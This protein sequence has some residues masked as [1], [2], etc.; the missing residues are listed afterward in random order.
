[1]NL[2]EEP[3]ASILAGSTRQDRLLVS[4]WRIALSFAAVIATSAVPVSGQ[5][6]AKKVAPTFVVDMSTLSDKATSSIARAIG[7]LQEKNAA[8]AGRIKVKEGD[9]WFGLINRHYGYFDSEWPKTAQTMAEVIAETNGL[10]VNEPLRPNQVLTLP[11]LPTRPSGH[12]RSNIAQ[13]IKSREG[14]AKSAR[15]SSVPTILDSNE[16]LP[17]TI[18]T[19]PS[20][21][22]PKSSAGTTLVLQLSP[23]EG[24]QL[25]ETLQADGVA[26]EVLSASYLGPGTEKTSAQFPKLLDRPGTAPTTFDGALSTLNLRSDK[27]LFIVDFMD[28]TVTGGCSHGKKVS[29]VAKE[30]LSNAGAPELASNVEPIEVDFYRHK[31]Q[32]RD[33]LDR[34]IARNPKNVRP[35]LTSFETTILSENAEPNDPFRVPVLYLHAL[36][37]DLLAGGDAAAISSSFYVRF[38]GVKYLPLRYTP[39]SAVPLF[40]AVTDDDNFIEDQDS[41]SLVPL[42]EFFDIHSKYGVVLVG[43]VTNKGEMI[44]MSSRDGKGVTIVGIADG[45]GTNGGC[46]Q[47]TEAATSFATP[48]LASVAYIIASYRKIQNL[49]I[50]ALII[51]RQMSLAAVITPT[52]VG[53]YLAPG[54]PEVKRVLTTAATVVVKSDGSIIE[55]GLSAAAA[56]WLDIDKGGLVPDR[57]GVG[58]GADLSGLQI[59]SDKHAFVFDNQEATWKPINVVGL[60]IWVNEGGVPKQYTDLASF[61]AKY[62][63]V[64]TTN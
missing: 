48:Q 41:L 30:F 19:S 40:N 10:N 49:P 53:K 21:N 25:I 20:D 55:N 56:N 61:A 26:D 18:V 27:K 16:K 13:I 52:L 5:Q 11:A 33:V 63:A 3:Y 28:E 22:G 15:V 51:R 54:V 31:D 1:M 12:A 6:T 9:S 50:S 2:S 43:G 8:P 32:A 14:G 38:D 7:K 58:P 4:V 64:I 59:T 62:Q 45:W 23:G 34:F 46:I 37:D 36:I 24:Q 42:R 44:G 39:D 57:R 60:S 17:T 35:T 29:E 47:P